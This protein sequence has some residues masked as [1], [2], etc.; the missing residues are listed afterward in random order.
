MYRFIDAIALGAPVRNTTQAGTRQQANAAGNHARLI[1][2]YV[3]KQVARH[4]HAVQAS[5]VLDENHGGAVNQLVLQRQVFK[6]IG[7]RLRHGLAPQP[8]GGQH[9][10]LVQRPDL[11]FAATSS[12]EASQT[13]HALDLGPGVR[14]RVPGMTRA[15]VLF[16]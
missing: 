5:R 12:Q 3:T 9:I 15:V 4:H 13:S 11:G 6:L 1:A 2:D 8:A 16:A 7:K 14:L 10:G